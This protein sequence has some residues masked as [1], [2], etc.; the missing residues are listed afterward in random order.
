VDSDEV[1]LRGIVAW[2][3]QLEWTKARGALGKESKVVSTRFFQ[4]SHSH[5]GFSPVVAL[6]TETGTVFNGFRLVTILFAPP[7]KPLE[8]VSLI[9][10]EPCSPG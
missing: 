3:L 1:L 2:F 7:E 4:S 8:T 9:S 10:S 5:R 6:R